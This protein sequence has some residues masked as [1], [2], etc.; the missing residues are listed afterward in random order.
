M[1]AE[2]AAT[3]R[4]T[5]LF[6]RR[7]TPC[8]HPSSAGAG[9]RTRSLK[10][11]HMY[12]FLIVVASLSLGL[13]AGCAGSLKL[14]SKSLFSKKEEADESSSASSSSEA[15][16]ASASNQPAAKPPADP[17]A[18][19]RAH[20]QPQIDDVDALLK[21]LPACCQSEDF[22]LELTSPYP[23][24]AFVKQYKSAWSHKSMREAEDQ[25]T[26]EW[27]AVE[28]K[29]AELDA[30]L[31]AAI[32]LPKDVYKA[33]DA[34]QLERT[35]SDYAASHTSKP[36][37]EVVLLDDDWGRKSGSEWHGDQM[38]HYDQGFMRGFVVVKGDAG[39]GEVWEFTPRKDFLDGGKV[40]FDVYVPARVTDI[41]LANVA[42][43]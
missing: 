28:A 7:P 31:A 33:R 10:V 22:L 8:V 18:E 17:A 29:F 16:A 41:A 21:Q 40:K 23:S 38:V 26:P 25:E 37:V 3:A 36:V 13:G 30:A 24:D 11:E 2:T 15:A 9:D 34:K 12:K 1:R 4:I 27:K 5:T 14:D 6:S 39:K 42:A 35:F 20:Y 43:K 19:R 32:R